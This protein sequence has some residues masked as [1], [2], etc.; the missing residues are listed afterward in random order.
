MG[1]FKALTEGGQTLAHRFRML[2]Q[3]IRF[4][5]FFSTCI[6]ILFTLACLLT[7]PLFDYQTAYY[8]YK[9]HL[10]DA[11]DI[12]MQ[13]SR[14]YYS[15]LS[16]QSLASSQ[17]TIPVT[18]RSVL[19][20]TKKPYLLF[21]KRL[22]DKLTLTSWLCFFSFI[23][24]L[25]YFMYRGRSSKYK[26]HLSGIKY[27]SSWRLRIYLHLTRKAS[28]FKL[29]SLPMLKGSEMQHVLISGTTGTGKSTAIHS[30]LSQ[31]RAK[32]ER[33]VIVDTTGDF[34][35]RYYRPGKDLLLNPFHP[36][37]QTWQ[38]WCEC[39]EPYHF[40]E[41]V[42]SLLPTINH[43]QD[44]FFTKAGRAVLFAAFQE[45]RDL[46]DDIQTFLSF[47]MKKDNVELYNALGDTDASIYLDPAGERTTVSIRATISN[48]IRHLRPLKNTATPL[49]IRD[50]VLS[51]PAD[52]WLF[53][54]CTPEQRQSVV[55]LI[56]V[57]LSIAL[58]AVQSRLPQQR[59]SKLW[60]V[61]D[62][63]H[64]LQK[65]E[66]LE[67]ALAELRKYKGCLIL[68]TQDISQLDKIYG[69]HATKTILDLCGT[70]VCFRQGDAEIA[71]RMSSLFGE[72]EIKEMQEG[73]SY[74]AHE[75]R[76]GVTLSNRE[77]SSPTI[78]V[79]RM[80]TLNNLEAFVKLPGKYPATKLKFKRKA[81]HDK[82]K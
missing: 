65:L 76:D 6:S 26:V 18:P 2:R 46:Q 62:E 20:L 17:K 1:I 64:S 59:E 58:N 74:G 42:S 35:S 52:Q 12:P 61:V 14:T 7:L 3:V 45:C 23:A 31:L 40:E 51:N 25:L 81:T 21:T 47:L 54:T 9:A 56:S 10:C 8:R 22:S 67:K 34:L 60:F 43:Y 19:R 66:Y 57:W 73:I 44:D 38:P 78:S 32:G 15:T 24:L 49:S 36:D 30:L 70:K 72:R 37:S 80:L 5:F 68:A 79:S 63:L 13:I 77:K 41:I 50:W 33:G 27:I 75:M 82:K 39:H 11:L 69:I 4:S 55:P 71:R 48:I 53:L 16:H 28:Q 29:A